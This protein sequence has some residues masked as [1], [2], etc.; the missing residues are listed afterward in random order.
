MTKE[1]ELLHKV[2]KLRVQ[3]AGCAVAAQGGI[4]GNL[5]AKKGAYGWSPAYQD[6]LNLRRKYEKLKKAMGRIDENHGL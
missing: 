1:N 5:V 6:V 2:D 4:R 3:L